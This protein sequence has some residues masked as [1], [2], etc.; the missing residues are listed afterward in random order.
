[1]RR[2]LLLPVVLACAHA[3][4]PAAAQVREVVID[5]EVFRRTADGRRLAELVLRT[6][7]VL[8]RTEGVW[9][10][11]EIEGWVPSGSIAP[12]TREG[13]NG[14]IASLGGERLRSEPAGSVTG[15]LLEGFLVD[16]VEEREGWSR[17]RRSGWVREAALGASDAVGG[18][19]EVLPGVSAA[20]LRA[21]PDE[22][23]GARLRWTVRFLSLERAEP[24]RIDFYEGEP[25]L[26]ARAPDPGDGLIYVAVPPE[27]L[28]AA[29]KLRPLQTLDMLVKVR[30][31]RSALLRVP[32]L[33]LLALY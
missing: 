28:A 18:E 10:E 22:Y 16:R 12:A 21:N 26:L 23:A 5:G 33:D 6:P 17:I 24:E 27:L 4:P 1:M 20:D 30:T 9:A 32:I 19:E 8:K 14:V 7:V 13:H 25:F 11:V 2:R 15:F 3:P 29:E 31:G